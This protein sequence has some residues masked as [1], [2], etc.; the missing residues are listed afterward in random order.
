[1][2]SGSNASSCDYIDRDAN[3]NIV[4][5][6]NFLQNSGTYNVEGI[7]FYTAYKFDTEY[8]SFRTSLDLSYVMTNEFD[9]EDQ[10][11]VQY[12]DAGYP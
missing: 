11:G 6:R 9:G 3:G 7:D 5:L 4:D 8:G 10:V 2:T 1:C 12:G